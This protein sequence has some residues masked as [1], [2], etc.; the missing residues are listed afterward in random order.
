LEA[1]RAL[2][3][4]PHTSF[5][6]ED[7]SEF[8]RNKGDFETALRYADRAAEFD[9]SFNIY[10]V[11]ARIF[12]FQGKYRESITELERA[13]LR[14][15]QDSWLRGALLA[16][17]YVRLGELERAEQEIRTAESMDPDKPE[18]HVTRAM[19]YTMQGKSRQAQVELDTIAS[20]LNSDYA[21]A[22]YAAAIY[23]KQGKVGPALQA[24]ETALR[25][26]NRW[27]SW[28]NDSWFDSMRKEPQFQ[29]M[30]QRLKTEFDLI[31]SDLAQRGPPL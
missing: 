14:S 16:M 28:Y 27:A 10:R 29:A 20:F 17:S 25:L 3:L 13:I 8:Y 21:L 15:P 5:S 24:M 2:E 22:S 23:A 7:L 26:G 4:D 12:Q 19:L 9:P 18:T 30:L 31:A 11:R 6:L 1:V